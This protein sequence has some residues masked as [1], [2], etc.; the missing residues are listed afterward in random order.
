MHLCVCVCVCVCVMDICA[1]DV[2][3]PS[4]PLLQPLTT[5][6]SPHNSLHSP[7]PQRDLDRERLPPLLLQG[8]VPLC[9]AQY[10]RTFGTTRIP[11]RDEGRAAMQRRGEE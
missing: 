8:V 6:P 1:R 2:N 7:F 11:S 10:P 3:I 9:M 5:I 4:P